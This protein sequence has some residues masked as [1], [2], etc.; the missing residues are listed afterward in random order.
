MGDCQLI[1]QGSD[2][3][4]PMMFE[5]MKGVIKNEKVKGDL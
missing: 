5:F 4:S 2:S 3:L 1:N